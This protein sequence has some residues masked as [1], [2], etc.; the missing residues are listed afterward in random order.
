MSLGKSPAY[1]DF[2]PCKKASLRPTYTKSKVIGL[3]TVGL[4]F[5][6]NCFSGLNGGKTSWNWWNKVEYWIAGDTHL[7]GPT[8]IHYNVGYVA[9]AF[10]SWVLEEP[11]ICN[12]STEIAPS[13]W[14]K[15]SIKST[16]IHSIY[17]AQMN[18]HSRSL[19]SALLIQKL[20]YLL[21]LEE[22]K[23]AWQTKLHLHKSSP[24][25]STTWWMVI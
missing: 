12:F 2:G 18:A 13:Q 15:E 10:T 11:A 7:R 21:S 22:Q 9:K 17:I 5:G 1:S 25:T 23:L 14:N 4:W 19:Q 24:S 3:C 20:L 6:L 8:R 16:G